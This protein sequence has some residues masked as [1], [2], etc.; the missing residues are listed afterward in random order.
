ML[1]ERDG[2]GIV[3]PRWIRAEFA[4]SHS[5]SVQARCAGFPPLACID[6]LSAIGPLAFWNGRQFATILG[7]ALASP[8]CYT[9]ARDRFSRRYRIR[10]A[11]LIDL[12][13]CA[14]SVLR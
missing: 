3:L 1:F 13:G 11:G 4:A 12:A 9:R 10:A 8:Y 6:W 14:P 7:L 2:Q 5:R